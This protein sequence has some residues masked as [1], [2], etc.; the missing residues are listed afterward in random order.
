MKSIENQ[1]KMQRTEQDEKDKRA[2]KGGSPTGKRKIST[3]K[4]K[5]MKD[6]KHK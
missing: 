6:P 3:S 4:S 1:I 5:Y 2:A